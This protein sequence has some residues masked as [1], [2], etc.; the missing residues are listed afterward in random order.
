MWTQLIFPLSKFV[1]GAAPADE[2]KPQ[3]AD[4]L[5]NELIAFDQKI[6]RA[7]TAMSES[8]TRELKV[9]GVPFF[10]TQAVLILSPGAEADGQSQDS[11][12]PKWSQ[13]V[14]MQEMDE[15]KRRMI[16]YL[17]DMYKD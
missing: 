4:E 9:L 11:G 8:M 10:G 2:Q 16:R 7:Q 5:E 14:T 12:R 6:H 1:G 3:T 15:L 13:K 17:E